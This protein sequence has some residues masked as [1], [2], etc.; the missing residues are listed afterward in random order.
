[1]RDW[2]LVISLS[3]SFLTLVGS[4]SIAQ[5]PAAAGARD[6]VVPGDSGVSRTVRLGPVVNRAGVD[7]VYRAQNLPD[8]QRNPTTGRGWIILTG[9]ILGA[10]FALKA[11]N[12][13]GCFGTPIVVVA[14]VG[15]LVGA[16][17]ASWRT[18]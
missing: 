9:A 15:A 3:A 16:L 18:P 13:E 6:F 14:A 5:E 10:Y 4:P 2:L 17:I 1:M 11:V 7:D 8:R 12:C